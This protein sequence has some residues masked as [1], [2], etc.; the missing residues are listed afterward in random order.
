VKDGSELPE[1]AL[2]RSDVELLFG[3]AVQRGDWEAADRFAGLL[4]RRNDPEEVE[5]RER[6]DD[7]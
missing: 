6:D 7:S 3:R 1:V 5:A 2:R 4:L